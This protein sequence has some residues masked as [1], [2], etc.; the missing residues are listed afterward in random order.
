MKSISGPGLQKKS[1]LWRYFSS[2]I[3]TF[4]QIM[5]ETWKNWSLKIVPNR[6]GETYLQRNEQ[7]IVEFNLLVSL[8]NSSV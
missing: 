2:I 4:I 6:D 8:A 5:I 3:V 1:D 7:I